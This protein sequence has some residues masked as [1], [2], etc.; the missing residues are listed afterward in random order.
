M[1]LLLARLVFNLSALLLWGGSVCL[2][3]VA[4][5]SLRVALWQR[6]RP[7]GLIAAGL[8]GL[9]TLIT[10]PI[11]TASIGSSWEA[12]FSLKMLTLVVTKTLVGHA[13]C[14]QLGSLLVLTLVLVVRALRHPSG[15]GIASALML[16]T[17]TVSGHTAMHEGM[18]GTLHR[19]NDWGHLLAGG[20]WLGALVPVLLLLGYLRQPSMRAGATRALIRFSSVGH[21]AV[22]LGVL[23][24]VINTWLVVGGWPLAPDMLYQRAL[25]L[26][27]ALVGLLMV[28]ALF[29][30]YRLVPRL[31]REAG[32][33]DRL[34]RVS[35]AEI[36]ILIGV[37]ALVGWFG[38]LSPGHG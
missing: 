12:G 18:T 20:F 11:L 7:W 37:V 28:M 2:L 8:S 4:D 26:K 35:I 30:R 27:V 9:A 3:L 15:V 23:T 6:L 24:G 1:A 25:W 5:R 36:M 16:A 19:L 33:L 38:T 13:W 34:R 31:S 29:N 21:L 14:W 17:L 32:A 10:L 22:A